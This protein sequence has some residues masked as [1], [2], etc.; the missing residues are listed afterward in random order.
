MINVGWTS[1]VF[2]KHFEL[3]KYASDGPNDL[4]IRVA[5]LRKIKHKKCDW[6]ETG[7][8]GILI[9]VEYDHKSDVLHI[10]GHNGQECGDERR[11]NHF[12]IQVPFVMMGCDRAMA[13]NSAIV[14][15]PTYDCIP[16]K[17]KGRRK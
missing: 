1:K 7:L 14:Q 11:Y 17:K 6:K 3:E 9:D 4:K 13:E 8:R 12:Q 2:A 15:H 10:T 16:K 5:V